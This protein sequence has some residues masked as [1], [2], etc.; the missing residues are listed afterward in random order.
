MLDVGLC[1]LARFEALRSLVGGVKG[2]DGVPFF[3]SKR[4]TEDEHDVM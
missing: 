4:E 2:L 1:F 3:P